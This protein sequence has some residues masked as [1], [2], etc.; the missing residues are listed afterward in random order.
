MK[1]L[2]A[3]LKETGK[4]LQIESLAL[5]NLSNKDVVVR[6]KATSLCHTDLE[7]VEGALGTPVPFI[8]GHEAAGV[9]ESVGSDVADLKVGDHVVISWNPYC[10]SCYFCQ[11]KQPI[12]CSQYR[13]NV[14]Q[15][16][17]FDG[18]PRIYL[19]NDPVHQLMYAGSF[20][21]LAVVTEE[22]A[23]KISKE[24][25]FEIACLIGCGVMTGV[26]AALNIAKITPGATVGVI[27]CGAVGISAIQGARLAG[28]E[29]I[30]AIDRDSKKLEFSKQFGVTDVIVAGN[31]SGET[32][33]HIMATTSGI[34]LDYVIESAG[35]ESAF[36]LSVEI[37]RPGGQVV[38]L[39]KVPTQQKVNF[40]WGSLMGEK[41]IHRSSYGGT[42]PQVD[43][44]FLAQS[45][46]DGKLLLDKYITSKIALADI[47]E[48]FERLKQG[49]EIRSVIQF[50]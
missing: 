12:I 28:A 36:Q 18:S 38:W 8:P 24:V 34:G 25:P 17:H 31:D 5:K 6:I 26:G 33:E 49:L 19:N 50:N 3:V 29:K 23:V 39:G 10:G 1:F 30:I 11:R 13:A 15:S 22:C 20:A 7:A 40:R 45:Y 21:E 35:N 47:N 46:L 43:F 41:K 14:V 32:L 27:G 9:V 37:V 16:F 2:G 42:T 4:L 44:P 48:G